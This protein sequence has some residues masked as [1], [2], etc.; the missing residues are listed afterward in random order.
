ML[1]CFSGINDV[2]ALDIKP[3]DHIAPALASDGEAHPMQA[4]PV[5]A[6]GVRGQ[7]AQ[8]V[9]AGL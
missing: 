7:A 8:T 5:G 1:Q 2:Y 6:Q 9:D 4:V 3:R